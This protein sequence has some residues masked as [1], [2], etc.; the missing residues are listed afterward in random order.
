MF[1]YEPYHIAQE[2]QAIELKDL[3]PKISNVVNKNRFIQ[4]LKT[5]K[6]STYAFSQSDKSTLE[7]LK[8]TSEESLDL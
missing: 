6:A 2:M 5:H 7:R 4:R 1:H 3:S 8:D